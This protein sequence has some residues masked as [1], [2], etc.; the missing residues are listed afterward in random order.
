[1][2]LTI[3]IALFVYAYA[4]S[5]FRQEPHVE[6]LLIFLNLFVISMVILVAAGNLIVLFFGWELIG[7]TSF[8]LI[9]FWNGKRS[10]LKAGFKAFVFNR[11][12]DASLFFVCIFIFYILNDT[13][14]SA[15]ISLLP[16]Y[17][18]NNFNVFGTP[19]NVINIFV[20]FLF[21]PI[22][23]KSAQ[24]MFHIWLPDSMEAP[25]P[26]SAL[27]HSATLVSAGIYLILR[28]KLLIDLCYLAKVILPSIGVLTALLGAVTSAFQTDVKRILAYST[29]SHC[30][31]LVLSASICSL[32]YTILYL[33]VHGFFKIYEIWVVTQ[34]T[35][36]L[37]FTH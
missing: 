18:N 17:N 33:Y 5:Y 27:I 8:F 32:E 26:A 30:G 22:C 14:I 36:H 11:V 12:S 25:V 24:I 9:N 4:F 31:F 3:T 20:F 35:C 21:V 10:T 15:V 19:V 37:K 6:R 13:T 16:K 28:F 34:N 23:I 29:I 1:M 7:L 2:L